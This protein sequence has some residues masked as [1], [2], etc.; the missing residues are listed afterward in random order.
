MTHLEDLTDADFER[1]C[2]QAGGYIAPNGLR[3]LVAE[4]VRRPGALWIDTQTGTVSPVEE[5]P[6]HLIDGEGDVWVEVRPGVFHLRMGRHNGHFQGFR[7]DYTL[8]AI[9]DRF[10]IDGRPLR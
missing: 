4:L 3:A 5:Q 2:A 1:A 10:M 6:A 8:E 7:A 9:S